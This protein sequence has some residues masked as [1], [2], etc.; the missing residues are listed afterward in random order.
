MREADLVPRCFE[1]ESGEFD[2]EEVERFFGARREVILSAF[3]K[4]MAGSEPLVSITQLP[5]VVQRRWRDYLEKR[6]KEV[7][8]LGGESTGKLSGRVTSLEDE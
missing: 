5:A 2:V 7:R 6:G 1:A 3:E 8:P 4:G